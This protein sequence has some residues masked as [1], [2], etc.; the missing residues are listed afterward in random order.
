LGGPSITD[1]WILFLLA[2]GQITPSQELLENMA[3]RPATVLHAGGLFPLTS[4]TPRNMALVPVQLGVVL[5]S[6]RGSPIQKRATTVAGVSTATSQ[7]ESLRWLGEISH[8]QHAL[9]G[10]RGGHDSRV[11]G[12]PG[13]NSNQGGEGIHPTAFH[14][15]ATE[16]NVRSN[17]GKETHR[18]LLGHR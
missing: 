15:S 12:L 4:T 9:Q 2:Q 13:R 14:S 1:N 11:C 10:T 18:I 7:V 6:L 8:V 5:F 3:S 16:L 17:S